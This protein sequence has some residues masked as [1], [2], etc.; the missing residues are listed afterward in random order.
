MLYHKVEYWRLGWSLSRVFFFFLI[1]LQQYLDYLNL[2]NV[3]AEP[4]QIN[5]WFYLQKHAVQVL[6][7]IWNLSILNTLYLDI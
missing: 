4:V 6:F 1:F 2:F 7:F 3:F 5:C